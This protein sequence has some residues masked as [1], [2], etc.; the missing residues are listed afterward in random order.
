MF[1]FKRSAREHAAHDAAVVAA[2]HAKL[3]REIAEVLASAIAQPGRTLLDADRFTLNAAD[4]QRGVDALLIHG[5]DPL[6]PDLAQA[7][8]HTQAG[9]WLA[10]AAWNMAVLG[11]TLD[12]PQSYTD[13]YRALRL[14]RDFAALRQKAEQGDRAAQFQLAFA[15]SQDTKVDEDAPTYDEAVKW[16]R[17]AALRGDTRAQFNLAYL[18]ATGRWASKGG[19]RNL[20]EDLQTQLQQGDLARKEGREE[21]IKWLHTAAE[22]GHAG[23]QYV[24]GHISGLDSAEQA[25]EAVKWY[26]LAAEAGHAGAQSQLAS[27][28]AS[29]IL[30]NSPDFAPAGLKEA[31]LHDPVEGATWYRRAAEQG[32]AHA[33]VEL[34]DICTIG[35]GVPQNLAEAARWYRAA[36]E[37]GSS[38][39]G[40]PENRLGH[41]Y[42]VGDGVPQNFAEGGKW[43]RLAAQ[44]L[45]WRKEDAGSYEGRIHFWPATRA[46][47]AAWLCGAAESGWELARR[48]I[49]GM[50]EVSAKEPQEELMSEFRQAAEAG[51]MKAQFHLGGE[52]LQK[53]ARQ[54]FA[55]AARQLG[56]MYEEGEGVSRD[57]NQ[58]E[59]Y[60]RKA[61]ESGDAIAQYEL[62]RA[63]LHVEVPAALLVRSGDAITDLLQGAAKIGELTSMIPAQK[64]VESADWYGKAAAQ[65][66]AQAQYQL[67]IMCREGKWIPKDHERAAKLFR[68]AGEQ[69]YANAQYELAEIY[70]GGRGAPWDRDEARRWYSKA[71]AQGHKPAKDRLGG[72]DFAGD[73]LSQNGAEIVAWLESA[74]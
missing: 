24:L 43:Y 34:G 21:A 55:P 48:A 33:Q 23:A 29:E 66:H 68:S 12:S 36:A 70:S 52:W 54:G 8:R 16:W 67:A 58:S 65:G 42:A 13:F 5:A 46:E 45:R 10:R 49:D 64:Y 31:K 27:I 37:Q 60:Y 59:Y 4:M 32:V 51:D 74:E 28:F 18:Y 39:R 61:A 72:F 69:G 57:R 3:T 7:E 15:L 22:N 47:A 30:H 25:I 63:L 62:G 19:P 56:G 11:N 50:R 41:M 40:E 44:R 17:E 1:G 35:K 26:R 53:A 73:P 9:A 20:E 38:W 14:P 2:V 6:G 71:A